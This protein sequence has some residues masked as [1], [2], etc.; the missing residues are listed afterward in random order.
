MIINKQDK[1]SNQVKTRNVILEASEKRFLRMVIKGST[2]K[3]S[4]KSFLVTSENAENNLTA[5]R[6]NLRCFFDRFKQPPEN[7]LYYLKTSV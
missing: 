3:G 7:L 4:T 1:S 2:I 5:Q 6:E